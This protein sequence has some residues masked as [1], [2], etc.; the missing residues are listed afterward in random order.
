MTE[1][2]F[3]MDKADLYEF[4]SAQ[5]LGVL[6]T[7]SP[8]GTPQSALVGIAVTPELEIVFDSLSSTR[9]FRNLTRDSRACFAIGWDGE[10]TVQFE[11]ESFLP[12]GAALTRYQSIYFARWPECLSH[13]S[14]PGIVYF[15]VRPRWIRYSDYDQSP[16]YIQEFS[17]GELR[18]V[19]ASSR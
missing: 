16:L 1:R 2:A 10:Q 4:M 12:E 6:G 18:E 7:L 5:T 17:F 8:E 13:Q 14:W 3:S 15:V 19:H 9:K 11:G